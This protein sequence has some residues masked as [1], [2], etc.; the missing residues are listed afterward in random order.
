ML[1]F[2]ASNW[3]LFLLRGI[4]AIIFGLLAIF[5]PGVTLASLVLVWAAFA[6]ADGVVSLFALA[7]G[8][9]ESEHKWLIALQGVLGIAVGVITYSNPAITAIALL[10]YIIAWALAIGVLQIIAAIRLRKEITGEFWLFLSGLISVLFAVYAMYRPEVG[11]LAIAWTIG[12]YAIM[13]GAAM[14]AFAFT[15]RQAKPDA[16]PTA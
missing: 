1:D 15:V 11:A 3:W 6:F 4:I 12:F 7:T 14:I 9:T 13:I 16:K 8:R 10:L 2:C 5:M